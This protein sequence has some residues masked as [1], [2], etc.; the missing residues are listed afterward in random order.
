MSKKQAVKAVSFLWLS[1]LLGASCAFLTQ[2]I[3]ARQLGPSNFGTFSAALIMI[4][5]LSPLAGFGVAGY[6]LKVFGQ[7]GWCATRW[8]AGSLKYAAL[9]AFMVVLLLI[10]WSIY[11]P[12]DALTTNILLILTS[13]V[14]GQA[15]VGLVGGKI[16]L[17]E[18][19]LMLAL[20]QLLPHLMRLLLVVTLTYATAT[21]TLNV[22]VTAYAYAAVALAIFLV[23]SFLL[24][25]MFK[26]D[27][28]LKGHGVFKGKK[29]QSK[30]KIPSAY[31]VAIQAWPFG[32]AG[33]LYLIYYQSDII[34]LK[35]LS[36]AE[37]A[38]IYN[39]AFLVMSAVYLLPGTIYQKFML[40]KLHYWAKHDPDRFLATY[41]SGCGFML[42]LGLA[43]MVVFTLAAPT[44][45]VFLFG[46]QYSD[47]GD[48]LLLLAL[49]IPLRFLGSSVAGS[50]VS[51]NNIRLKTLYLSLAATLNIL[52][53]ILLI[54]LFSIYGA[55]L[56]TLLSE[57]ALLLLFLHGAKRHIFGKNAWSGWNLNFLNHQ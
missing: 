8:L 56:A 46:D 22:Q 6:W 41:Q 33:M 3:L 21:F 5:L 34:L 42:S 30:K 19:H 39:V 28:S 35:Y 1:S 31:Q 49:C 29:I 43:T 17:E 25:R 4:T 53:N 40:S 54:P 37:A 27:F 44:L 2:L 24:L 18:N 12:H 50:F 16:M 32:L 13:Y 23:G 55:A 45:V 9:S 14:F 57:F 15:V 47:V 52:L 51:H 11:G 10:G 36:G 7:E 20:W 38:G 48:L 26:G